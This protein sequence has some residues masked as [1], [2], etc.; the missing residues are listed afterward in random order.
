MP[1]M[2]EKTSPA[3]SQYENPL[4]TR[5]AGRAMREI[6]S[7]R[8]RSLAWRDLWI[9]LARSERELGL[10]ISEAQLDALESKRD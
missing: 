9:A 7:P 2:N 10:D 5:Y 6:L 3:G 1:G 8:R 4:V